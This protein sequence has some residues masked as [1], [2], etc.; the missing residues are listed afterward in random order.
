MIAAVVGLEPTALEHSKNVVENRVSV[1]GPR[2]AHAFEAIYVDDREAAGDLF[3]FGGENV[4][5][6][7][8]GR[9]K[10]WMAYCRVGPL[11]SRSLT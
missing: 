4:D 8:F 6:K 7:S 11:G 1:R 5:R 2:E 9:S 3:L 10:C